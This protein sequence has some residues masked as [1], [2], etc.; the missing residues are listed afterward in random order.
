MDGKRFDAL[1]RSVA[2]PAT[3]RTALGG[4]VA[5][6]LLAAFGIK[7][8]PAVAQEAATCAIDFVATVRQGPT[9]N[10]E[11]RGELSFGLSGK[12]AL[13]NATLLLADGTSVPVVGQATGHALQL[14][15]QLAANQPLIAIGV[16]EQEIA[17]CQGAIDG[18]VTGPAAGDLGDFHAVVLRAT[19]DLGAAGAGGNG[20]GQKKDR[21]NAG[22]QQDAASSGAASSGAATSGGEQK[23][24]KKDKK[25]AGAGGASADGTQ[26]TGTDTGA[27]ATGTTETP[28]ATGLTRCGD[29]CVDLAADMNNCG[30]CGAVCESGLVAVECRGGICERATCPAGITFCGAVDGCR[31]LAT[32]PAHCGA[33]GNACG[34][35]FCVSGVCQATQ[36]QAV[37]CEA[38]LTDCGGS[39]VDLNANRFACGSCTTI[40]AQTDDCVGG[41]CTPFA[42]TCPNAG[43]TDCGGVCVDVSSSAANCG[44]CGAACAAGESCVAGVCQGTAAPAA[45]AVVCPAG[46]TDCSGV[47]VDLTSDF[48]NCGACG[49]LCVA[50]RGCSGGQCVDQTVP[51]PLDCATIG[52][53]IINCGGACTDP[54][55][56]PL[57]C[58]ACG[59]VCQN[60]CVAGV[61]A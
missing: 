53:T 55:S 42:A 1:S 6:G 28:C 5:S 58:G 54:Q 26:A 29:A 47:C 34:D 33:C 32:D 25:N 20:D 18:L 13:E 16:G 56:D 60:Q 15:V 45:Q 57:N 48:G 24:D 17:A 50:P 30:A 23:K 35:A 31:D 12:G 19:G 7:Q 21:K 36:P 11:L 8:V 39:C 27:A 4:M 41:V 10:Q 2:T 49:T 61:C 51:P 59:V 14:R 52:P 22:Q 44:A 38:G 40:C 3:R 9:A 37:T 43:E 46:E